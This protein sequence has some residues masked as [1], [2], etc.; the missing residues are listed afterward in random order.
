MV[1]A[2]LLLATSANIDKEV[3][4]KG[5]GDFEL[6]G[7]LSLPADTSKPVPAVLLIPGSGPTD[8]NGN[9]P[10]MTTD[11]LK[12]IAEYLASNGIGSLRFDKR[13]TLG[14]MAKW[15]KSQ[16]E[17]AKFFGWRAFVGDAEAGLAFLKAQPEI[18][19]KKVVVGGHSEGGIIAT[20]IAAD[21]VG[22][23]EAPA[24]LILMSTPGRTMDVLL[25]DQIPQS[26]ARS[27]LTAEQQK[28]YLDY[29]DAAIKSILAGNGSPPN[30][31]AGL[32]ALFNPL[33]G[34][35]LPDF[36]RADPPRLVSDFEEP[37]LLIQGEKDI[38]ILLEKDKPLLEAS[39]NARKKGSTEVYVVP[40]SSHNL[41]KV[42][43]KTKET[44]FTGPVIPEVLTRITEWMKKL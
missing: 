27:G 5:N 22:R 4:F 21:T 26:L 8:R 2:L 3:T 7:T 20:Q 43:D 42:G 29:M 17:L 10:G 36:F 12:Q 9:Q 23:K 40:D 18:D 33:N 11:V 41:K 25:R 35:V 16:D 39:L 13:A 31:P 6:K 44:G 1:P 30:P 15:P 32:G 28:P 37:V 14:Y 38:Q 34:K 19:S 24:G